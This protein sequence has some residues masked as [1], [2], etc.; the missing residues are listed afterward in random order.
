MM[1]KSELSTKF[2]SINER[3]NNLSFPVEYFKGL[4]CVRITR[5]S[6]FE[7]QPKLRQFM[8]TNLMTSFYQNRREV[9]IGDLFY[10]AWAWHGHATASHS[11]Y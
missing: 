10:T 7:Q 1:H 4:T 9:R 11:P 3:L 5:H 2:S 8:K 6:D